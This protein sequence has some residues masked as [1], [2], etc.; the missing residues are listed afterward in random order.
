L[1]PFLGA[2]VSGTTTLQHVADVRDSEA[3]FPEP[4]A[5][6]IGEVDFHAAMIKRPEPESPGLKEDGTGILL[7]ILP[8]P[9]GVP[10]LGA[11][12]LHAP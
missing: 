8:N 1:C 7:G 11:H 3:L 9:A 10:A 6:M 4:L 2:R 12:D 5:R